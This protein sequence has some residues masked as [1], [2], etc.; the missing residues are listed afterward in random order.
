MLK[1]NHSQ[2]SRERTFLSLGQRYCFI[3]QN[4][5]SFNPCTGLIKV[6]SLLWVAPYGVET[7]RHCVYLIDTKTKTISVSV[8]AD[9]LQRI[10]SELDYRIDVC[11]VTNGGHIERVCVCVCDT[12]WNCMSLC[13]CSHQF[14]K[15][16]PVSFDFITTWNQ[17]VVLWSLC[18]LPNLKFYGYASSK[19]LYSI[20]AEITGQPRHSSHAELCLH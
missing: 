17:G 3:V 14:C 5:R 13:N 16:I 4:I 11:R 2:D 1:L 10:W 6:S 7:C 12:T 18:I 20:N 8:T 9:M 15:N 19:I